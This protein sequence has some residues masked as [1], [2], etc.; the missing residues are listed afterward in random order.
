[1]SK[2]I[3]LFWLPWPVVAFGQ[4]II[5]YFAPAMRVAGGGQPHGLLRI[6]TKPAG[7]RS[8]NG[9]YRCWSRICGR[10]AMRIGRAARHGAPRD[11]GDAGGGYHFYVNGE[12]VGGAGNLRTGFYSTGYTIPAISADGCSAYSAQP[13]TIALRITLRD[14]IATTSP[15]RSMP[16]I[17]RRWR[18]D[19]AGDILAHKATLPLAMAVFFGVVG[20][21][22]L[23]LFY[24]DRSRR[25]LLY[26][27]ILCVQGAVGWAEVFTSAI[28][29]NY[30]V[31]L[32]NA[33]LFAGDKSLLSYWF[34]FTLRWRVAACP[35]SIGCPWPS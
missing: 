2:L 15:R 12:L 1:M 23:G 14:P 9:R 17:W 27:S 13:V 31:A 19:R 5:T 32:H 10:A 18:G 25:E 26:L 21:M 22:L 3:L 29:M 7:S 11:T 4:S 35:V 33:L 16:E 34:C 28:L 24:Y 30:P 20:L 8:R 6:S